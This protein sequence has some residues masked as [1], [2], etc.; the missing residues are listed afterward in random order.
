METNTLKDKKL[1]CKDCSREFVFSARDQEF[2]TRQGWPDPIRCKDCRRHAKIYRKALED[3]LK[4]S[5]GEI[6][7]VRCAKCGRK[8]LSDREIKRGEREY[9]DICWREIKGI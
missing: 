1:K 8:L 6:H 5:V 7:E 4:I 9:C 2:F 3:G